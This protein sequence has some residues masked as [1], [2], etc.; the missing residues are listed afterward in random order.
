MR[1][2]IAALTMAIGL[3]IVGIT[4]AE[5]P[6]NWFTRLF[7]PSPEKKDIAKLLD[8]SMPPSAASNRRKQAMADKVRR[9][10]VC[11]KL[12]E[13]AL[14]NGDEAMLQKIEQLEQRVWELFV[15]DS[16]L[17]NAPIAVSSMKKGGR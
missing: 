4:S 12:R 6:G 10:E 13:I 1:L 3:G 14:G 15:A 5:E 11:L 2:R 7:T 16:N 8:A 17:R 9:E